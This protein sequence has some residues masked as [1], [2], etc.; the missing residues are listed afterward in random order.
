MVSRNTFESP[1]GINTDIPSIT[2]QRQTN[3]ELT[4]AY[5]GRYERLRV[6]LITWSHRQVRKARM[7]S[8]LV[9]IGVRKNPEISF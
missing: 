4:S 5:I 8:Q 7:T 6:L 2:E 9:F 3:Q 1:T